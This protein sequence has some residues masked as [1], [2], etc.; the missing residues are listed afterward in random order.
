MV[1]HAGIN[2]PA[3]ARWQKIFCQRAFAACMNTHVVPD[4]KDKINAKLS[5]AAYRPCMAKATVCYEDKVTD[6]AFKVREHL[7]G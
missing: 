3:A 1:K 7:V 5:A 4:A 2:L 6:Q